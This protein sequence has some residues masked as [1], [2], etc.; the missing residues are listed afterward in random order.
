MQSNS[1]YYT[2]AAANTD[3]C[4]SICKTMI[5]TPG[6]A[7][8]AVNCSQY[9]IQR[10][11]LLLPAAGNKEAKA[12]THEKPGTLPGFLNNRLL[13]TFIPI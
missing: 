3:T 5:A 13:Y 12:V 2:I 7:I 8:I 6:A 9:R 10:Y 4:I 1:G 11:S